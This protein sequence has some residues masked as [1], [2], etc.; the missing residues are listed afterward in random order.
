MDALLAG[1]AS[2]RGIPRSQLRG[3][4]WL[5]LSRGLYAPASAEV[6]LAATCRALG[7][8]LPSGA[9][10]GEF[11]AASIFGW[12]LP[13]LPPSTPI[14]AAVPADVVPP[15]RSGLRTRRTSL[16]EDERSI[17]AGVAVTSAARTLLDLSA[18]LCTVDLVVIM[19]SALRMGHCS[20]AEL[21]RTCDRVGVRGIRTF[22]RAAS[23]ADARSES[24]WETVLRLLH[25]LS[26]FSDVRPQVDLTDADGGWLARADLWL[27]G[28]RRLHEYDGATHRERER[29]AQDLAREKR[30]ARAGYERYGYTSREILGRPATV[31]RDAERAFGLGPDARRL[32]CWLREI[33]RSLFTPAGR[34]RLSR[35]WRLG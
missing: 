32:R 8:V 2:R 7:R 13:P 30:L 33:E 18:V 12:W 5:R 14:C 9:V 6:D 1:E 31:I 24:P 15:R 16:A 22:R 21:S 19:D 3:G 4:R 11:T 23:L 34:Q 10:H 26:G 25:V 17:V 27:V 28:T 20:A 35:A 29:H